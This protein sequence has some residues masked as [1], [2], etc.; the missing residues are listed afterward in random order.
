M[1]S[2]PQPLLA[3]AAAAVTAATDGGLPAWSLP[4]GLGLA[5]AGVAALRVSGYSQL[6]Y[7]TA[8][9]LARHVRSGGAR[10]L[11]L[12]GSTR[13]LYYYPQGTVQVTVGGA[14]IN[15]G[16]WEQGGIQAKKV[17]SSQAG[18]T[19]DSIV[20]VNQM[21]Q[22]GDM[23]Q[24]LAQVYRV[25]KPGGTLIFIQRLRG[26]PLQLLLVG[27]GGADP[28]AVEAVQQY[29]G[30]D[31]VQW[32]ATL[33]GTDPHA[34]G[35]AVKPLSTGGTAASVDAEAFEQLRR[36]GKAK[37]QRQRQGGGSKRQ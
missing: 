33:E 7:I 12:G 14:D 4:A 26:G 15:A 10:V 9:M 31:F 6:E 1:L 36:R 37:Q 21:Q 25:L 23:Q 22:W 13:D 20:L 11:Q 34:V 18:S 24:L 27:S 28:A 19:A 30:W 2:D 3:D 16:L 32:D 5:L 17:L 29:G 35:V 8:A